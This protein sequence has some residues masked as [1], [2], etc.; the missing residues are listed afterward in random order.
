[1]EFVFSHKGRSGYVEVGV[2]GRCEHMYIRV[3][4][5]F[6]YDC[7]SIYMCGVFMRNW[8]IQ[9]GNWLSP[10]CTGASSQEWKIMSSL[11]PQGQ[12]LKA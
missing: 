11:E 10:K 4:S 3:Q 7:V 2:G 9:C 6:L 8:F 12:E 1:M 5:E